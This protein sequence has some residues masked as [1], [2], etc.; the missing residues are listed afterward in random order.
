MTPEREIVKT[1]S[2]EYLQNMV[3]AQNVCGG[4]AIKTSNHTH[5][6]QH[7]KVTV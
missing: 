5:R 6:E 3:K 4:E 1:E 7:E 2:L